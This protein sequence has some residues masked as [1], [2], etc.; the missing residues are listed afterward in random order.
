[1][2]SQTLQ[3]SDPHPLWWVTMLLVVLEASP[4]WWPLLTLRSALKPLEVTSRSGSKPE[5]T[6]GGF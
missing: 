5:V 1:M 6:Y 3:H 4:D 2:G